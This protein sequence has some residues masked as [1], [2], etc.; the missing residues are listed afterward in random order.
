MGIEERLVQFK[1]CF[2]DS[3]QALFIL[4]VVENESQHGYD[5]T[6]V[7]SN[8]A[9]LALEEVE[10]QDFLNKNIGTMIAVE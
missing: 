5:F 10:E 8:P 9:F 3:P 7:Y 4:Q 2:E 6:I 1:G